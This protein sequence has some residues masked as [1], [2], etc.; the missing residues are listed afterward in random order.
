MS[1]SSQD[2]S[3]QTREERHQRRL[4]DIA[5]L[6]RGMPTAL[7]AGALAGG[8]MLAAMW[9]ASAPATGLAWLALH[10]G[11]IAWRWRDLKRPADPQQRDAGRRRWRRL[12]LGIGAT[13]VTWGLAGVVFFAADSPLRQTALGLLLV[14]VAGGGI[15]LHATSLAATSVFVVPA[16]APVSLLYLLHARS[17][18]HALGVAGLLFI[19]VLLAAARQLSRNI[20]ENRSLRIAVESRERALAASQ[21]KLAL[22]VERTPVGIVEWDRDFRVV[23]WN[24][25][26]EKIFGY[27]RPEALRLQAQ[28]LLFEADRARLMRTM[29]A[30]LAARDGVRSLNSNRHRDGHEILCEWF[31]TPLVTDHGEVIGVTS[32]VQDVTEQIRTEAVLR[33][34]EA[35][36]RNLVERSLAGV[37]MI[38]DGRF[39]YV[40]PML[41]RI[42]GYRTDEVI[43]KTVGELVWPDDRDRVLDNIRKRIDGEIDSIGYQFRGARKDGTAVE[44]EVLGTRA[45][46]GGQPV[47]LGTLLDVSEAMAARSRIEHMANF[48]PLTDLPNRTSISNLA[49]QLIARSKR[50]GHSLTCLYIDLDRF[51]NVNDTLGHDVGDRLLGEAVI[52]LLAGKPLFLGSRDDLSVAH[53]RR[54]AV[55]IVRRDPENVHD[56]A[57]CWRV[58]GSRRGL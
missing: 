39:F 46:F 14:A 26:A 20:A 12:L 9:G 10:L 21:Q 25:A 5:A 6:S 54:G 52:V 2:V 53:K 40:N 42:F 57:G 11:V 32:L 16:L 29:R 41:A 23:G 50:E 48:D 55:M 45:E 31:N 3:A 34:S 58:E 37:Y 43:G 28:D 24:P 51:K 13:G 36:F 18:N 15:S 8:V 19:A 7:L 33:E 17:V 38:R 30:L 56:L 27:A 47:I 49:D 35:K 22:H 1:N 4:D 44:V